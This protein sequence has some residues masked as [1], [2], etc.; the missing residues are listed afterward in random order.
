MN[1]F[2]ETTF[3][4]HKGMIHMWIPSDPDSTHRFNPDSMHKFIPDSVHKVS[5]TAWRKGTGH[6]APPLAKELLTFDW[7][8]ETESQFL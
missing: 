7:C 8:W 2:K 6:E 4:G 5:L 3:S 1:D